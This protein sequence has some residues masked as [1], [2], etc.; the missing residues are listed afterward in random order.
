MSVSAPG[1]V[2]NTLGNRESSEQSPSVAECITDLSDPEEWTEADNSILDFLKRLVNFG[3]DKR[4]YSYVSE[5]KRLP[6]YNFGLGKRSKMGNRAGLGKRDYPDYAQVDETEEDE[7]ENPSPDF[8]DKRERL[9]SFGLGKRVGPYSFGIGKRSTPFGNQRLYGFGLGKRRGSLYNFGLGKR[10]DGRLYSFGL[11]KRPVSSG[12]QYG[13]RFNFGLGKRSDDIDSD[14]FED[15]IEEEAKRLSPRH[16]FGFGLGK[17]AVL[18]TE[19]EEVRNEEQEKETMHKEETRKNA[20][21]ED[22]DLSG[23]RM[24]RNLNYVLGLGKRAYD[25]EPSSLYGDDDEC[26]EGDEEFSRLARRPYNFDI[27]KGIPMYDFGLGKRSE[28]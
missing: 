22:S 12:K 9:Y 2:S 26:E 8:M 4:A 7:I 14:K 23:R 6:V 16:R 17:R 18:P 20:T 24:K 3:L 19:L 5:Y 13:N 1:T 27:G 21:A 15:E 10:A 25:S 11:G 28:H